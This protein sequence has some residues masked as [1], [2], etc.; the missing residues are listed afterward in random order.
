MASSDRDGTKSAGKLTPRAVMRLS[1][2]DN[3][4]VAL[5][6]L[7]SGETVTLDGVPITI[8][9]NI[10]VGHKLAA[11]AVEK[12]EII[13][14]YSCPIG[15]ATSPIAPGEHVHTHNVESNYLPTY[16]IPN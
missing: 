11:Q 10:A 8:R 3:V 13:L 5:R 14:K 4:A 15:T 9:G 7:K 2:R 1:P 16:Q 12:G 6:A